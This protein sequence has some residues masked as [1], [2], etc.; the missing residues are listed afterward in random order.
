MNKENTNELKNIVITGP[1]ATGKTRLAIKVAKEFDGE[2]ISIDSRQVY[3]GMD[4]GTGK[5]LSEYCLNG[6]SIPYHL[7]DIIDPRETYNLLE[8]KNDVALSLK[9]IHERN[10]V[11]VLAGGTPLYLDS[12]LSN[13]KIKGA[14]PDIEYRNSLK[15]LDNDELLERLK[16]DLPEVYEELKEGSNRNRIIRHLEKIYG[17]NP[18]KNVNDISDDMQWLI[19][20]VYYHRKKVHQRI[21]QRL[22]ERLAN[23][24]IEEVKML[25]ENGVSWEKLEF[26]GLEYKFIAFYLQGKQSLKEMRDLL[27]IKIRQFAK[28]QDIWFRKMEREGKKIYWIPE[29]DFSNASELICDFF[30]NKKLPEPT[31]R[32]ADIKY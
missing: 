24:M 18:G 17:K 16:K 3:K 14:A 21:E 7:I 1:T 23:G 9:N 25:H 6:C 28:R 13:Y 12:I 5:D 26:F 15:D 19:F 20:G 29:G 10:K 4:I 31:I 2:I 8:F 27:L 22:D 30:A 32:L 11:P